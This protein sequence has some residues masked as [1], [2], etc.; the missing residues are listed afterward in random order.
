V[1]VAVDGVGIHS[2]AAVRVRLHRIEGATVFRRG[3]TVVPADVGHVVATPRC[4]VLGVDGVTVA[5]VE[6]V[7]AALHVS[8]FHAG[9]LVEVD[10]PELPILDGSAAPWAEA[11]AALGPPPPAPAPMMIDRPVRL[12]IG[13]TTIEAVPGPPSLDVAIDFDHPAIGRQRWSGTPA[14]YRDVLAARTFASVAELEALWAQGLAKGATPG[15]G[16]LFDVHGPK[17]DL[18]WPD[19]PVRHKALDALGDFALLGRPLGGSVLVVRGSHHAH[20]TFARRLQT[21]FPATADQASAASAT[22]G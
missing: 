4:T 8:G 14:S 2:G 15:R 21:L 17:D 5:M 11:V 22:H 18:R 20:V 9:V 12:E 16:I 10:G 19:E 6:H 7:L 1:S 13:M 3:G